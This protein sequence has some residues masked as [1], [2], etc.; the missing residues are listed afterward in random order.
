MLSAKFLTMR[1]HH[2]WFRNDYIT[3]I[4]RMNEDIMYVNP[5][6]MFFAVKFEDEILKFLKLL[7][8]RTR[9]PCVSEYR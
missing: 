9:A 8:G 5:H 3:G 6:N 7:R 1:E 4:V 2:K